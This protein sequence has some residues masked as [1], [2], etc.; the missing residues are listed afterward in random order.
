MPSRR[1]NAVWTGG[2]KDGS[3]SFRVGSGAIAGAYSFGTRFE[4]APGTNPEELVGAAHAACFS[5]FLSALLGKAGF[6][7]RR[8][9]T[10]A[11]VHLATGEGGPRI[12]KIE[13]TCVAEVPGIDASA[14]AEQAD[15]AKAN[16]PISRALAAV[17]EIVLD[18]RLG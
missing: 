4:E 7:P 6:S 15:N 17:E 18:A 10:D 5:M 16:C 11:V 14:F 9:A 12:S 1:A 8:I 3:G 2:L 13:L